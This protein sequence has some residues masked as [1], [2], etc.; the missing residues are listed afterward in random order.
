MNT[1]YLYK[2]ETDR[3]ISAFYEVYY[4]LGYGFL[5]QVYQNALYFGFLEQVYQNAL[6]FELK[7]RGFK[8]DAQQKLQVF[9]KGHVVGNYVAD[10][11]V[12]D[13][14]ILELK[15]VDDLCFAHECQLINYLRATKMRV[16]LLLNFGKRPSVRRKV[17]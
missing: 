8:C 10:M 4:S 3:I 2:E 11:I 6:Y 5:E 12:N 16:G 14:I 9:Y 17:Y 1:E 7:G 13:K 15:A